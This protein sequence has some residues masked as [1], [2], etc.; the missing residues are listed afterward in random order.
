MEKGNIFTHKKITHSF[1]QNSA[2][3]EK[4]LR[5]MFKELNIFYERH[6]TFLCSNKKYE[7]VIIRKKKETYILVGGS[8]QTRRKFEKIF[9][10]YF[11]WR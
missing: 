4:N 8:I 1:V 5:K 2:N 6:L 3:S 10:K 11:E 9:R 7:V